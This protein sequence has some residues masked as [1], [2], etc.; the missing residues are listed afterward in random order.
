[1][2]DEPETSDEPEGESPETPA[3]FQVGR[4]LVAI[5]TSTE[6]TRALEAAAQLAS[7]L[8]VGIQGIFVEDP[9]LLKLEGLSSSRRISLPQG[10]GESEV[11][12]GS[13]QR[14]LQ[15][16]AKRMRQILQMLSQ[17]M[18]FEYDFRVMRGKMQEMLNQAATTSDLA[19][20]ESQG[21]S[22]R[23]HMRL[24]ASAHGAANSLHPS[25]LYL[26]KGVRPIQ[27]VI[28]VFDGTEQSMKVL[29]AGAGLMSGPNAMMTVLLQT[30]T[31]DE[32]DDMEDKAREKLGPAG[33][34]AHYRRVS[35]RETR[36]LGRM[37]EGM[38]GDI[39]VLVGNG[40]E[41]SARLYWANDSAGIVSDIPSEAKLVPANWGLWRF[42]R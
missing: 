29:E 41:T 9:N 11:R 22:V 5:D 10:F 8:H 6:C 40:V 34:E 35:P 25:V 13:M 28:A 30:E 38:H 32:A 2:T 33:I 18:Q 31:R 14:E 17:R 3:Q 27:S 16:H 37:V 7:H 36:W 19:V 42:Q 23:S 26:Q 15:A 20:V 4:V 21:R 12:H 39:G 24:E 1:M